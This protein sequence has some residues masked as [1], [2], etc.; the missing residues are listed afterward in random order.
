MKT[1]FPRFFE[2]VFVA[3]KILVNFC[4]RLK[5]RVQAKIKK[6]KWG[7]PTSERE[8]REAGLGG[9]KESEKD[10]FWP[11][12]LRRRGKRGPYVPD[13]KRKVITRAWGKRILAP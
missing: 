4:F 11:I 13:W 10:Q 7:Q 9:E 2:W 8:P 3:S 12:G 6:R 1:N 5:I